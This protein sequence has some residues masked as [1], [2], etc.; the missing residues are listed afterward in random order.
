MKVLLRHFEEIF[1]V[2]LLVATGGITL[3]NV[4]CRYL[5]N[6][7]LSWAEE[8]ATIAFVWLVM[9]GA[10]LALKHRQHFAVEILAERLPPSLSGKV[11]LLADV[12]TV[13]AC[14]LIFGTGLVYASWGWDAVTS[15]T[16]ISRIWVYAAVPAGGAMLTIRAMQNLLED[17]RRRG[18]EGGD[19]RLSR[20]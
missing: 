16:E 2:V 19:D 5:M 4:L 6:R 12:L 15:A 13:G 17:V 11:R 1:G 8:S 10:S 3:F 20:P 9:L 18:D 14:L 7:P